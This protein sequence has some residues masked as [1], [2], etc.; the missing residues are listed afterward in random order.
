MQ[1]AIFNTSPRRDGNTQ[2]MLQI[3]ANRLEENGIQTQTIQ[4][5]GKLIHG[6]TGWGGC[7]RNIGRC[8]FEDDVINECCALMQQSQGILIGS[9]TDV[10]KRQVSKYPGFGDAESRQKKS[11]IAVTNKFRYEIHWY[12]N[13]GGVP[14]GEVKRT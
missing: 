8:V 5:G 6:C 7:G 13:T 3:V 14:P 12:K 4:V 11:G 2:D 10:Y 9:P 1:V